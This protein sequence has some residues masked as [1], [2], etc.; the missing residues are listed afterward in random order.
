[1]TGPRDYFDNYLRF[2]KCPSKGIRTPSRDNLIVLRDD[3]ENRRVDFSDVPHRIEL[4]F[5]QQ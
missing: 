3:D 1:V 4:V 2:G 5:E